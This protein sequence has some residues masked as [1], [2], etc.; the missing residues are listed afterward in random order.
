[1]KIIVD[2][3]PTVFNVYT[4]YKDIILSINIYSQNPCKMHIYRAAVIITSIKIIPIFCTVRQKFN[5]Q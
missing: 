4:R 5:Q 1:M 2:V 3:K